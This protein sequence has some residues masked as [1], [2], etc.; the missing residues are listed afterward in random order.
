MRMGRV[1]SL[2][3]VLGWALAILPPATAISLEPGFVGTLV[4][5]HPDVTDPAALQFAPDGRLFLL[6][7]SSGDVLV[8]DDDVQQ[9]Q[10]FL[11]LDVEQDASRGLM[12]LAFDPG[13]E[14]NGHVFVSYTTTDGGYMH[15]RVSRFTAGGATADPSSEFV[16]FEGEDLDTQPHHYG[17][18]I[19]VGPDGMLYISTGDRGMSTLAQ[20]LDSTWGKILRVRRDGTIPPDNPFIDQTSGPDRAIWALGLRNPFKIHFDATGRLLIN[21]VGAAAWEEINLGA[22]GANFGW[23][24]VSGPVNDPRYVDPIWAYQHETG[25]PTG[26]AIMGGADYQPAVAQLPAAFVGT[27]IVADHCEGWLTSV[28]LDD[29]DT[30]RPIAANL[31]KPVDV[32]ISPGGSIYVAQREINGQNQTGALWRFD[33]ESDVELA[34]LTHPSDASVPI[35]GDATFSV[36][37]QGTPPLNFQWQ[38]D[39][40]D[41]PDETGQTLSLTNLQSV[42]SGSQVTVRVSDATGSIT[43][44]AATITVTGNHRPEATILLP[45]EG[46]TY[47]AG[48]AIAYSGSATDFEDGTTLPGSAFTW[49]VVFHHDDHTH[50]FLGD[51]TGSTSGS[52]TPSV[53]EET[54][55]N[56]FYRLHLT[57]TD[58]QGST[59]EVTRDVT[60][61]WSQITLS[62]QPPGLSLDLDGQPGPTPRAVT[63]VEGVNRTIAAPATQ[64]VGS[65]QYEFVGW[66]DGGARE[67]TIQT[68]ADDTVYTATY[69]A[70]S[71]PRDALLIVP[72][73][74]SLGGDSHVVTRLQGLG[75]QVTVANDDTVNATALSG[76]ELVIVSKVTKVGKVSK[77]LNPASIPVLT[78]KSGIYDD[79]KLTP[80]GTGNVGNVSGQKTVSIRAI[81]HPL[82]P[83][84]A[85]TLT[86]STANLTLGWGKPPGSADIVGVSSKGHATLFTYSPGDLRVG[87]T[88]APACR[89]AFPGSTAGWGSFT[90]S[91]WSLFDRTVQW[92]TGTCSGAP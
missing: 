84:G 18:D 86:I 23:P 66:S 2:L 8:F 15:N 53:D 24:R 82:A 21:D 14:Q 26:C 63:G 7:Q 70:V 61:R 4:G 25:S 77:L 3:V 28:D 20:S 41:L 43:S 12:G 92:A 47:A 38:R 37:A 19:A 40:L 36:V 80:G 17:G 13:F 50:P 73:P 11:H 10:P 59:R 46:A 52:F 69:Q 74:G 33:Y 39:G 88:P 89:V 34:I 5:S 22:R 58:S 1:I 60:P 72:E 87:G 91:G 27:F 42:D 83:N 90:A 55:S 48:E 45:V 64:T 67:H 76:K 51:T 56:V 31:E 68:P 75:F 81:A 29:N 54:A 30:L 65:T 57:V 35:G 78:W 49:R 9:T 62:T 71:S 85:Q 6:E 32:A 16:V 79:L 44:D